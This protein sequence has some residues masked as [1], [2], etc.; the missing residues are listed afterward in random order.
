MVV[1]DVTAPVTP[2]IAAATGEC[3]VTVTAPTT[4]DN[5]A[6]TITGTTT[7]AL[8]YTTVGTHV[9]TWTF[10]DGHGNSTTATQNVI[11]TESS[12]DA[13]VTISAS[14]NNVCAGTAVTFT[15]TPVNG[16]TAP[17]Y[18]WY[19]NNVATGTGATYSYAPANG[20]VVKVVMTSGLSCVSQNVVTSNSVTMSISTPV[21]ASVTITASANPV[22]AGTSVTFTATPV[23]GGTAPAYQWY[24]NN[25]ATGTGATYSYAPANG[26]VV[27]VVMTS[28]VSCVTG[29]PATS[30]EVT[31]TVNSTTSD[32]YTILGLRTV[33]LGQRNYVQTGSVGAMANTGIVTIG[34][35][36]SVAGPGAFVK[37]RF[38]VLV[39]PVN[40]PTKIYSPATYT[41]PTMQVN[42]TT[43]SG[44]NL[45]VNNNTTRTYS[46]N[47]RNVT[48]GQNCTVTFT[49]GT[50]FGTIT[51]GRGSKVTFNASTLNVQ[52]IVINSGS[53]SARTKLL[54]TQNVSV[55]VKNYMTIGQ[56]AE[57]NTS[58]N[59]TANFF[60]GGNSSSTDE[61]KVTTGGSVI[62]NGNVY[63]PNGNLVVEGSSAG[64]TYMN[65]VFIA[66]QVTSRYT[67]IYWNAMPAPA[68][69]VTGST[70][71][72]KNEVIENEVVETPEAAPEATC[73]MV[74]PNGFSPDGDG[75]NELFRI[76]CM[77]K[78]PDAKISIFN[79]AS[80]LVYKKE[81]Y[82]NVDYWGA[83]EDAWWNGADNVRS[84]GTLL[85]AGTYVYQIQ[86]VEG[87][88]TS[89]K[90]G[91][92]FLFRK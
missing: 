55:R 72:T 53:S 24:V 32:L 91:T 7:D 6:G 68:A 5:C 50:T 37:A 87:D 20:E 41:L 2:T 17:A 70:T 44:S 23:N 27:K 78:Y 8:T 11:V 15:A 33:T 51:I 67:N 38:I 40:V 48:I 76:T 49:T 52:S 13:S 39:N 29:S 89:V 86:L 90:Q 75:I 71:T 80:V 3:S 34:A 45:T 43:P 79:S 28:N 19:V 60:I 59:Y 62:F 18:Q 31:M 22:N 30:N 46:G 47:Y 56:S 16:G 63:I 82:G 92:I 14:A 85:P 57:V 25:V 36:S 21:A 42:N 26:E 10:S 65:G 74:I 58:G 12:T 84:V 64:N 77:D 9:I 66:D 73:T 1:D 54:F 88:R 83:E 69:P 81:H 35:N 61:F 4:T